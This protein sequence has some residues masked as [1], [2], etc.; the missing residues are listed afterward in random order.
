M[1]LSN[2]QNLTREQITSEEIIREIFAEED[3][4]TR[5]STIVKIQS[6][7]KQ[8]GCKTEFDKLIKAQRH[9]IKEARKELEEKQRQVAVSNI[10]QC[11]A[12]DDTLIE[13]KTGRWLINETGV[14]AQAY[15]ETI[16][17]SWYPIIIS[18]RL[19]NKET[20][21]SKLEIT[22][23]I[24]RIRKSITVDRSNAMSNSKIVALADYDFPASSETSRSLV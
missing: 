18:K 5:E 16:V 10:Y 14:T 17:A 12:E 13:F 1:D 23:W 9:Q 3:E 21:K 19:I 22:W 8:I 15:R 7:A 24:N 4:V 11:V 6:Q 20:G 2:P